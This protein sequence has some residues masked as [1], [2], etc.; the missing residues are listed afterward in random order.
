MQYLYINNQDEEKT[1]QI[2]ERAMDN[3]GQHM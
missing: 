2:M 1:K 3:V